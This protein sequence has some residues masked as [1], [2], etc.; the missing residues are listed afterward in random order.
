VQIVAVVGGSEKLATPTFGAVT[1]TAGGFTFSITNYSASNGYTVSTTAGSASQTGGTVTQ[2]GLGYS[3]SATVSVYATRAGY[4][5]SDTATQAGTSSACVPAGCTPPSCTLTT[6]TGQGALFGGCGA[7][8][9]TSGCLYYTRTYYTYTAPSP[10]YCVDNC[11]NITYSSCPS[12]Y[13]TDSTP[14]I[15]A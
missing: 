2:S 10:N 3:A 6:S 7:P 5:T 8:G 9:C 1:S 11:G 14:Y 13:Y 4:E 15:C 12:N